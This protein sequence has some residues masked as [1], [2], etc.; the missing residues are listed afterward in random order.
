MD[1][2]SAQ[3]KTR[4]G[5]GSYDD[6]V[7]VLLEPE[8]GS[9]VFYQVAVNPAGTIFDKRIE[10]CPFGTYVQDPAWDAPLEVGTETYGDRWVAEIA[11]PLEAVGARPETDAR[12]GF[13]FRRVHGRLD[14]TSDFQVP[15][16]YAS[17]RLGT[18]ILR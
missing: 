2:I 3:V 12:W 8:I 6:L 7:L 9:N 11:I 13:N 15:L 5:F 10:I 16:W 14:A 17:D 18:L 1:S 4:D